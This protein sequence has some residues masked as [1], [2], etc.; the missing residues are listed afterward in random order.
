M[1]SQVEA[2][3]PYSANTQELTTNADDDIL[4]EEAD[5]IDP[6]VQYVLLG[7]DIT[8]GIFA[9]ISFGIDATEDTTITPAAYY[10]E[11]GGVSNPDSGAGMGGSP[12]NGTASS[13][14]S[15]SSVA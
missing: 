14:P 11:S 2:V 1:I 7:E 3:E 6:F 8:D 12:P 10:T 4:A 5:T 13:G 15:S 9:W